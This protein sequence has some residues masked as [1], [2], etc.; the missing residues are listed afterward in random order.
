MVETKPR[1]DSP[2]VCS[3]CNKKGTLELVT[4][5]AVGNPSLTCGVQSQEVYCC[6]ECKISMLYIRSGDFVPT[7]DFTCVSDPIEV[8]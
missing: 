5:V 4:S 3:H 8:Y 6:K 2:E 7:T 1:T